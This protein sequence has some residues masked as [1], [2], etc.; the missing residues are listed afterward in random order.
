MVIM[1]YKHNNELIPQVVH[2]ITGT[3]HKFTHYR[4][5]SS[6]LFIST[7]IG[8][9]SSSSIAGHSGFAM[10]CYHFVNICDPSLVVQS[11]NFRLRPSFQSSVLHYFY[12]IKAMI[13]YKYSLTKYT[14]ILRIETVCVRSDFNLVL[15]SR[16]LQVY[17]IE[18]QRVKFPPKQSMNINYHDV[19]RFKTGELIYAHH[20]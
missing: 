18:K 8:L 9:R 19:I 11:I 14:S 12:T 6:V 17:S 20:L 5:L 16:E 1:I 3:I 15:T 2:S 13:F 7:S 4:V 10:E